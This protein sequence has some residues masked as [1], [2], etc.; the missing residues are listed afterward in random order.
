MDILVEAREKGIMSEE[1]CDD[2]IR[3]VIEQ[4]KSFTLLFNSGISTEKGINLPEIVS[5][6][7]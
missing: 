7:I 4:R 1:E 6:F 5:F 2:F 3:V